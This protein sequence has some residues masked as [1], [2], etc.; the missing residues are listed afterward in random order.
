MIWYLPIEHEEM[1]YTTSLDRIIREYLERE[2]HE[3]RTLYPD[4]PPSLASGTLPEGCFLNA[5]R[6]I[7]FKSAQLLSLAE[8][9]ATGAIQD[10][11]TVFLGDIWFP[12]IEALRYL[13]FFCKK[14]VRLVGILHAGSFTDTD[15][16]RQLE[17]WASLQENVWFSM[18]DK[19]IVASKFIRD[20]VCSKRLLDPDK[21]VVS[22]FPLDPETV[23]PINEKNPQ[24]LGRYSEKAVVLFNGRLC[25]EKQP[26]LFE[27][28]KKRFLPDNRVKFLNTQER[29]LG[30]AEYHS[31]LRS[32]QVVVSFALQENFGFGVAEAVNAGCFPIVPNRLVYPEFYPMRC[33]YTTFEGACDLLEKFLSL[34]PLQRAATVVGV[35][36]HLWEKIEPDL[37]LWFS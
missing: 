30:K 34:T 24:D 6:T 32:S 3:H 31:V 37:S 26:H 10:G 18:F 15:F 17:R 2:G 16:V 8:A 12:G 13:D 35:Q 22:P 14:Q 36:R 21:V 33:R 25:D 27:E 11:D 23:N 28:M 9:Y 20:D 19:V 7:A 4:L 5:P 29:K 1:R